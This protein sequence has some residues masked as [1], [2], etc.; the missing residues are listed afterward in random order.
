MQQQPTDPAIEVKRL[1]RCVNDVVSVLALPAVW[2]TSDASRILETLLDA[3]A[4]I[5]DLD[6]LYARIQPD[7][8]GTPI[9]ALRTA[10]SFGTSRS[11]EDLRHALDQWIG[12]TPQRSHGQG[13]RQLGEQEV[14]VLPIKMGLEG[15]LGLI[16]AGSQRP[17]FPEQTESLVLSVAANQA[18]VAL[19]QAGLLMQQKHVASE[20]DREV[21]QRT[22]ELAEVNEELRKEITDRK[23][24]EQKFRDLLESAPDAMVV[25][26]GQGRIVLVNAQVENVFGYHREEL[27]GQEIEVLVPERLR[28][29]HVGHRSAFFAQ[30]RVRRMGEGQSLYGRR[31]DRTEFPV[32]ISLSPLETEEGTLVLGAVRDISERKRAEDELRRSE[33]FLAEAQSLSSTGSFCW[34]VATDEITWSEQLYRIYELE[35]GAPITLALIR[36]RVHPEDVALIEKMRMVDQAREGSKDFEWQYRLRMPDH[37]IKYMHAVAHATRDQ[38]GQ[39]EYIASVQDV[40]ARRLAEEDRRTSEEKH[41][42]IIEAA[43]DAVVSMDESGVILLANPATK[44]IFGYDPCELVGKPMTVLMPEMM[45]KMH[46]NGFKRY[47]DTGK[48]HLN[49]QGIEVTAQRKDG[50]EFPVEVS[51]GELSRDGRRLFTG[52]I[53]D[54]SQRKQAEE[55]RATQ[56]CLVVLRA[57]VSLAFGKEE[58]LETILQE[59]ADSIVRHLDAAFARIWTLNPEGKMLELRASAGLYTHLNGAHARIPMGKL[60]IGMIAQERKPVLTNDLIHDPLISDHDWAAKEGMAGFAGH[61]LVVGTRTL[62]VMAIFSQKPLSTGTLEVLA[63]V[64]DLIALGME[65]KHAEDE[66]RASE[67]RL[68]ETEGELAHVTRLTAMGELAASIAHEVNQPLTAVVNSGSACLRLLANRNLEPDV[69]R[70]ALEEIVADSTRASSVLA[71]IR[72]FIKKRPAEMGELDINEVIQEVLVL[73]RSE[74]HEHRVAI[75]RKLAT[76]LPL[77]LADRVQLQQVMLNLIKN[78]IEAMTAVAD[79]PHLLCVQSG[80]D[81]S[82]DVLVAVSDCGTGLGL[83]ADRVFTPFFTT[84]AN[85]MGMGLSISRSLIESHGGR[86]WARPNSPHG[87]VLSFTLPAIGGSQL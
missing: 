68:K 56:T 77:V 19:Q 10:P 74:M 73:V 4:G 18:T 76:G 79:R 32:E 1:Q 45:R 25:L 55:I 3:L 86:L 6:F 67:R 44:G 15:D 13:F 52:F 49:W 63:S 43:N 22:T 28:G 33:A 83:E 69:L 16:V 82:G 21:A 26:N 80:I 36:S 57:D 46:E 53:R 12:E 81:E 59:C 42:V 20:L 9:D 70:R 8:H 50:R 17:G 48:R 85:G 31:K 62:G 23:R 60:K 37:S 87:A 64:A 2:S 47:L 30:P 29:R 58:S 35:I 39:L 51:F 5:L 38:D 66:L 14:F 54:I 27:L 84:K 71:R 7:S 61:P 72:A 41:R 65:H 40:T 24:A 78:G 75:D 11:R 34:R